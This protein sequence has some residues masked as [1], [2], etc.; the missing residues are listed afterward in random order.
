MT[1]Q[2]IVVVHGVGVKQAGVSSDLLSTALERPPE[3][4]AKLGR[5]EMSSAR[6]RPHST[7][8]FQLREL[9]RYSRRD[10]RQTF[11]ARIRRYRQ[12][13]SKEQGM[14]L[15]ERVITDFYWGDIAAIGQGLFGLL[16]ALLKTILGLCHAIRENAHDVF[17][18]PKGY[19]EVM[20][21]VA[22][23]AAL[24]IHGPI[25]AI[26]DVL[27][28]GVFVAWGLG[29]LVADASTRV[30]LP[31]PLISVIAIVAGWLAWR[32]SYA[33]LMRLSALSVVITGL[34][35][36][37]FSLMG[38]LHHL[39]LISDP[40]A[41]FDSWLKNAS[42]TFAAQT[43]YDVCVA[44]YQGIY[45]YGLRLL[46]VM[47][48][49]WLLVFL[50][51]LVTGVA[52][53]V[54]SADLR[55]RGVVSLLT[56][57]IGLMT[58]L[59]FLMI[60][61]AWAATVKFIPNIV[62]DAAAVTSAL[63]GLVPAF[64]AL[65]VLLLPAGWV[66]WR[67]RELDRIR[68]RPGEYLRDPDTLAERHRLIVSRGM[69]F[70]LVAFI[71][72]MAVLSLLVVT[73]RGASVL[74]TIDNGMP[75]AMA[76]AGLMAVALISWFRTPL[77]TAL[78]I[79]ADVLTYLNDYS[80]NSRTVQS[81]GRDTDLRTGHATTPGVAERNRDRAD[82]AQTPPPPSGYWLRERIQDRLKV[83]VN[84][85]IRDERPDVLAIVAHSQGTVVAIDVIDAE[86]AR[87]LA[88]MPAGG[89]L[90]LVTMGSPYRHLHH[91]YFPSSFPSHLDRPALHKRN[92]DQQWSDKNPGVLSRW[93]NIFRIDDFVGTHIDVPRPAATGNG[94]PPV[95]PE[96]RPVAPNGHT[97]YWVDEN[98]APILREV[99]EF[100]LD[101]PV[102]LK[103]A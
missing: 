4:I 26:N 47:S 17:P 30:W 100:R 71:A 8:D 56:P 21:S 34:A 52:V 73:G 39:S 91:H 37:G 96:E 89:R 22:S 20:R 101:V 35:L 1:K 72:V 80:W 75:L 36:L 63:W 81:A 82:T 87:W 45:L 93:V 99:L 64:V 16:V 55:K 76:A 61:C 33:R 9:E 60:S 29:P 65:V 77:A 11:P 50:L 51:A 85:L 67:K 10:L 6:L 25:A 83:L 98:V 23:G 41:G 70:V 44:G 57:T 2:V 13:D 49:C 92:E 78:G 15:N 68:L 43:R 28:V 88:A 86:G 14:L 40:F 97:L 53:A 27:L 79:L 54:R 31:G 94:A 7:D 32:V 95:W 84:Q 5:A 48:I 38:Q 24:L 90:L 69:M 18:D 59:W 58:L 12:Y 62:P 46:A 3:D 42:C 102:P 103:P 66:Q 19:D 74:G